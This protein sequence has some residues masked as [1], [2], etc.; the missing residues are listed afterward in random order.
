MGEVFNYWLAQ[1]LILVFYIMTLL[2]Y[3]RARN[4]YIGGKIGAAINLILIFLLVLFLSDIVDYFFHMILPL[5]QDSV[6]VI[7]ILLRLVAICVLFFGGLKFFIGQKRTD[8]VV[9]RPA[10]STGAKIEPKAETEAPARQTLDQTQLLE[11][12]E[13][14]LP[15]LGRYQ[16]LKQLGRGAMGVVYLGRDPRLNRLTAIKTIRFS[17]DFDDQRLEMIKAQFYREAEVVAKLSHSNIV[18]IYDVGEDLELSYL[19][20]E[21]LEGESL[22]K[23]TQPEHLPTIKKTVDIVCQVCDALDYAHKNGIIHRDIKPVNIMVLKSGEIKVMDFGIARATV[24]TKTRTGVIK[25]TP[26]YMSPEQSKGER[27][28]GGSDIFSLGVVLYQLLTG[29]LPFD[30]ENMAAVMYQIASVDPDPPDKLNPNIDKAIIR[31][32]RKAL[33]K[34]PQD[35]Y[36]GAKEMGDSLRMVMNEMYP[37]TR[38]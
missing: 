8:G 18:T 17:D 22:E 38:G 7:K 19:A 32:L 5:S 20:M 6:L 24:G 34:N 4:E 28:T 9:M 33:E 25:G 21:Y 29:K 10:Q 16:I 14:T 30:G 1:L 36:A 12:D 35:R 11:G 27:V 3:L 31:I 13:K 15:Q 23:Y 37:T 2:V 26:Y